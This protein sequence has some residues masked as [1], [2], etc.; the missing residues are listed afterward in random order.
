M[1][2]GIIVINPYQIPKE[3]VHQANRLKDELLSLG[4]KVEIVTDAFL[5]AQICENKIK[6]AFKG[7]DFAIYLDKDKYQS[8]ILESLGI[9]LF[10]SHKAVRVCDDKGT[11]YLALIN[12]G[13]NIPKT[14]C[15]W[16]RC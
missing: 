15:I 7:V 3:S 13:L 8:E 10:N 5:R 1:G 14:I 2:Q 16:S 11:T 4:V 9:K 6:V 12:N